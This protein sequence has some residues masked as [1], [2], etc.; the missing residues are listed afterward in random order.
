MLAKLKKL[1]IW[2]VAAAVAVSFLFFAMANSA[3]VALELAPFPFIL[4]MRLFVFMGMLVLFGTFLGWGVASFEC[5][6]RYRVKKQVK[7]RITALE[8]EIAGLRARQNLPHS[9]PHSGHNGLPPL[10]SSTADA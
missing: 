10:S 4:E 6:Q 9:A 5:R 2:I 7:Q 3:V 8:N 1:C